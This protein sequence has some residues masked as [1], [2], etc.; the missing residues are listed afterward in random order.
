MKIYTSCQGHFVTVLSLILEQSE[1]LTKAKVIVSDSRIFR[2]LNIRETQKL[3][4]AKEWE[5]YS[6]RINEEDINLVK[7]FEKNN[8][9][10]LFKAIV[11]DGDG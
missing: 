6:Q 2:K 7:S 8:N 4:F 3:S 1:L 10:S 5:I 11:A 9:I